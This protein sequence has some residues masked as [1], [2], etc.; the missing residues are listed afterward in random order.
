M[1]MVILLPR[2]GRSPFQLYLISLVTLAGIGIM[3]NLSNNAIMD[4]MGEPYATVWGIFLTLGGALILLGVYWPK[5]AITGLVIERSG[6]VAL[7]GAC[8]IWSVLVVWKVHT[9]GLFSA[10]LTFG[11][12]LAC[13]AQWRWINKSVNRVIKAIDDNR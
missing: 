5:E 4:A 1:P 2:T 10:L 8:F 9:N 7:G 13:V 12:A 11:L 3:L 6:L